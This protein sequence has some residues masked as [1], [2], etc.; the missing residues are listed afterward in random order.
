MTITYAYGLCVRHARENL[1][2]DFLVCFWL[3]DEPYQ[4]ASIGTLA[5]GGWYRREQLGP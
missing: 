5:G 1:N 3:G 4:R 2:R